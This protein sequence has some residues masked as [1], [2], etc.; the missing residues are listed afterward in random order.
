MKRILTMLLLLAL[1]MTCVHAEPG[2]ENITLIVRAEELARE[3]DARAEN[4]TDVRSYSLSEREVD[5]ILGWGAGSHDTPTDVLMLDLSMFMDALAQE[6]PAD[7]PEAGRLMLHRRLGDVLLQAAINAGGATRVV[8]SSV[9]R[10]NA[11]FAAPVMNDSG[12]FL[13]LY[14]DATPVGVSWYAQE[15]AVS[16]TAVFLP[17]A[18]AKKDKKQL[19]A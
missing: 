7:A 19:D 13:L 5:M 14:E 12:L 18:F 3:L 1:T 11:T 6:I 16:M 2:E 17:D 9:A 15:G 4:E 8:A 10:R